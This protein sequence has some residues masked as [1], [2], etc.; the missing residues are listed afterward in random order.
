MRILTLALSI[1]STAVYSQDINDLF[2]QV[3]EAVSNAGNSQEAGCPHCVD[4]ETRLKKLPLPIGGRNFNA[5][6]TSFIKSDGTYGEWGKLIVKYLNKTDERKER[7][8]SPAL[9]GMQTVPRSCPNWGNMTN[10]QKGQF[11]V[12]TFASIAQVESSCDKR[13]VNNGSVPNPSDRPRGLFQLNTLRSARSWRGPNCRFPS[14]AENVYI[15]ANSIHC[16]LDIM[17]EILK[18]RSGEYRGNGKIFPTN[19][20]WEKLRPNHSSTGGD[21]GRLVRM[22][23]GCKL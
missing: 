19:S 10:D 12:W 20:Y 2:N 13:S 6:C 3:Q 23:P 15:A 4:G 11:W 22:F 8:F 18:G 17:S 21:I 1:L 7:F 5:K 16:S 9:P 14:G